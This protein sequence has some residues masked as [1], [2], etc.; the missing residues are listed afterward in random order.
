[1]RTEVVCTFAML[2]VV[3]AVSPVPV[4]ASSDTLKV[5]VDF[6]TVAQAA[7]A[8]LVEERPAGM[9]LSLADAARNPAVLLTDPYEY[10]SGT[11]A[12][13]HLL[14]IAVRPEL[15]DGTWEKVRYK[16]EVRIEPVQKKDTNVTA[17]ATIEALKRSFS[18]KEEWVTVVSNGNLEETFLL[19]LGRRLFGPQFS[20]ETKK[21]DFWQRD[22]RYVPDPNSDTGGVA[23]PDTKR[24]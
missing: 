17:D 14:K 18:G 24:W 10:A 12:R 9:S 22:P 5:F 8:V 20:L 3:C 21:K 1:M 15:S 13:D 19:R 23:K 11:L 2:L 16:L 6:K 7:R 4:D